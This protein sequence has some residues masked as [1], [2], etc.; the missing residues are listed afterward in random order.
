MRAVLEFRKVWVQILINV[1]A[2]SR[3]ASQEFARQ[4]D[5]IPHLCSEQS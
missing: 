1:S 4:T 5:Q 3:S 2:G